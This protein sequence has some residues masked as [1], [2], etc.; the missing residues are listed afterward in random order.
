[1]SLKQFIEVICCPQCRGNLHW[2]EPG[3]ALDEGGFQCPAC[4]TAYPVREGLPRL[5]KD[6]ALPNLL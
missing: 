1:M 5:L 3:A 6:E 4:A 2:Q